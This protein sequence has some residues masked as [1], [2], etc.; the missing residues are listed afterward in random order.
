MDPVVTVVSGRVPAER[1]ESVANRYREEL[2]RG[3]PPGIVQTMLYRAD[4][5]LSILTV[6]RTREDLEAMIAVGDEPFARR[7]IREAGG[8]P[9]VRVLDL[10]AGARNDRDPA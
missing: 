9:V 4:D 5:E 1:Q 7:L 3:L 2:A 10:L 8:A 6:W